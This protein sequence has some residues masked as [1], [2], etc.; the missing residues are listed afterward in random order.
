MTMN[1]R[2]KQFDAVTL[3]ALRVE[4]NQA[5]AGISEKYGITVEAGRAS[6]NGPNATFKVELSTV[7][8]DGVVMTREATAFLQYAKLL[9]LQAT[10]LGR[11]FE[12]GGKRYKIR[13]Y[14]PRKSR[15]PFLAES[16]IDG[17]IYGFG[18]DLIKAKLK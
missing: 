9:G 10:D 14:N 11:E 4:L 3:N 6:Y 17:K 15:Y 7:K 1:D 12:V 5:L 16:V 13:G 18:E 2:I 8:D